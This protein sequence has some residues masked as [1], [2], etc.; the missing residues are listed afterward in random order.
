M[1]KPVVALVGRPNVGKSTLFNRLAQE[2]LAVVDAVPGTTRDR[3]MA[4]A[5]WAG[6]TFSII[7]TGGIDPT[8]TGP[9]GRL[10]P[11]SIGSA[12]FIEQI[13][14]QAE[15]AIHDADAVL[16]ITDVESGVT[17]ADQEVAEIL[18]R[19][20]TG[21]D[22]ELRPPVILVVNKADNEE[23]R[24]DAYQFYELGIGDPYPISA[25]HGT[26]TGDMLD[27]LIHTF[28][29]WGMEDE[30]DES[31]RVAIVGKP[32]VGKSSLLNKLLG[33]E[34]AI[35]SP[36]PG[37]TRDAVDT[38]LVYEDIP[39]TLIDTA[40]IRR[41]GKIDPGVEKYSV[42]RSLRAIERASVGL[43]MVDATTGMTAQDTHIA[44]F[45]LDAWKSAVLL[46]NKW[47]AI[48]KDTYTM[49][50]YTRQVRHELNFMDYV[51]VLFISAL[52]GQRVSQVLP[53]ALQVH[54]ERMMRLS[55]S[56]LN[57]ILR[58]AQDRHPA[59]TRAGR[60][61]KIYY[62]TQVR[63]DP[64]TF[65]LYVNE[66]DLAHFTYLRYLENR[67]REEY[68]FLGTPIRIVLRKRK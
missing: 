37:T 31:V 1:T 3:L 20:Q 68:S 64:P 19:A 50:E 45:I 57:K 22:G 54:D 33:Q 36:I 25:L 48:V 27:A 49:V 65:L 23:R 44:G 4:D 41:R 16:F 53:I 10:E 24:T 28:K 5:D 66:P 42:L 13:R 8:D 39:M 38:P 32:N 9:D 51:P 17:P 35:V 2:R 18:R 12:D 34:R 26:G 43:L 47:D 21:Q 40:G 6:V 14:M 63:S 61:L 67:I 60:P 15:I 11:L 46:V 56:Q 62:G 59:P 55:T 52:T 30:E 58:K 29:D 7:D